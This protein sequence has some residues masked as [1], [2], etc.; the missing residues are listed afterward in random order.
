[1]TTRKVYGPGLALA[2]AALLTGCSDSAQTAAPVEVRKVPVRTATVARRTLTDEVTLTGTLKP[3]NQVQIVA[4]VPA[5]LVRIVRDEGMPARAGEVLALL[6][7]T[8]HRLALERARAAVAVAEANQAHAV[9]EKERADSL[10]KT[11]GITDKDRLSAEV[12]ARVA[13]AALTQARAEAAIAAQQLARTEVRAPFSGRVARRLA[14]PGSMLAVGAPLL[15]F[16]D[17][18]VL[19]FRASTP[20]A[21]YGRVRVGAPVTVTTDALPGSSVTG[22]VARITPLVDERNRSFEVVVEVPGG[23]ALVGG[24]F[25]RAAVRT[26]EMKDALVLPPAALVRDGSGSAEAFVVAAGKAE[27]RTVVVGGET[28]DAVQ[29]VEGLREGDVVVVSPPVALSSGAPVEVQNQK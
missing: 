8:D 3:R 26:G 10:V 19:E 15:T 14:D 5:R 20:S 2:A 12:S 18:A 22:R 25:A 11:G 27:R 17:D 1:M 13:E 21:Y 24:L 7:P 6:D 16:V 29:V 23:G 4:E 9:A 28:S